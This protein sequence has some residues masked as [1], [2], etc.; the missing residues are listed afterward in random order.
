MEHPGRKRFNGEG[1]AKSLGRRLVTFL[2]KPVRLPFI[3]SRPK[4]RDFMIF[5]RQFSAMIGAGIAVLSS[6]EILGKQVEH[7]VLREKIRD[8]A[9]L[10]RKGHSLADSFR[11]H[12]DVFPS[13]LI[14][15]VETG[16]AGGIFNTAMER[17]AAHFERQY[18]LEQKIKSATLYPKFIIGVVFL[19]I[20][21]MIVFVLPRFESVFE[22]MG[23][24]MPALTRMLIASGGVLLSY[25]YLIIL[26]GIVF[27]LSLK[28]ALK[29]ETGSFFYDRLRLDA[30]LLGSLYRKIIM[31]R[32]CR[33]LGT[34]LGSGVSLILSLELLKKTSENRIVAGAI[35][36]ASFNIS[37]GESVADALSPGGIFPAMV[38]EMA[39]VG[40]ET[41]K[42]DS[43]FSKSAD[44]FEAD[45][46]YTV[47]RLGSLLEPALILFMT[48][49][50]ALIALS[51]LL[52]MFEVYDLI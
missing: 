38:V 31:A 14:N 34:L 6:L 5:S 18:D 21:F 35:E 9:L 26:L 20:I 43:M 23:V 50:I 25:W 48:G 42:L 8:V 41:G 40:E 28:V 22:N 30:P 1:E 13:I 7:S 45:V 19:V 39:S 36:R 49:I 44:F 11:A 46:S 16:E 4:T 24:V 2:K 47:E 27:F 10:V 52:P 15:M 51:V 17:V 3:K 32:F 37:R 29:T 12:A 33:T